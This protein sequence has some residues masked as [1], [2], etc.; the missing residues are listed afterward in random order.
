MASLLGIPAYTCACTCSSVMPVMACVGVSSTFDNVI[1]PCKSLI[2][3]SHA[4]KQVYGIRE[5]NLVTTITKKVIS[6]LVKIVNNSCMFCL[7][8]NYACLL[9]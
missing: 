7:K 3:G 8:H 4:C 2:N 5:H 1:T 6:E 9:C